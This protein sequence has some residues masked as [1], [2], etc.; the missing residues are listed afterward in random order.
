MR[1]DL[2]ELDQ[3]LST[4]GGVISV[5]RTPHLRRVVHRA[6]ARGLLVPV[7]RGVYVAPHLAHDTATLSRALLLTHPNAVI[8]GRA[9]ARLSF[10]PTL[11]APRVCAA[12]EARDTP[13]Y[14]FSEQRVPPEWV[15]HRDG[16]PTTSVAMTAVD[17]V[18]ELGPDPV[19][20]ALRHA[21]RHSEQMLALMWQAL[22]ARPGRNGNRLRA[23][24]LHDSRGNP[25]SA[26]ERLSHRHLRSAH[27]KGWK[28]NLPI[29]VGRE[30]FFLD[31]AFEGKRCLEIDGWES[32]KDRESFERD[33]HKR[34]LL[35]DHGWAVRVFTWRS[36]QDAPA[37]IDAVRHLLAGGR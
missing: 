7:L 4:H 30:N 25:W 31:I 21:G 33:R 3:H 5:A 27:I 26:A 37:F 2:S 8:T 20:E 19:D 9:A 12:V 1:T 23:E 36:L 11:P 10:M 13:H 14:L 17:L 34:N 15:V 24:V 28:A 35:N 22:G 6:R 29:T 16:I 32:H 18:P